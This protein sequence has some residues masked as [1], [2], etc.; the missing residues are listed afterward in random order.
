[1]FRAAAG[2]WIPGP[3]IALAGLLLLTLLV[4]LPG[5]GGGWLFDD[6]PNLTENPTVLAWLA[7]EAG[8]REALG[9][10]EASASG[11]PLAMASLLLPAA[12]HG[13]EPTALKLGNLLLH[14]ANGLL[15]G[16]LLA[17]LAA[18]SA[19]APGAP[20]GWLPLLVAGLWLLAPLQVSTVL[21]VIQRMEI[22]AATAV[23]LGLLAYDAARS[24]MLAAQPGVRLRLWVLFPAALACG[25]LAKESAVAL[26]LLAL[27][28]E[29]LVYRWAGDQA[30]RRELLV[31]FG[32]FLLLPALAGAWL[33]FGYLNPEAYTHRDFGWSERL[34]TQ[35]PVLVDYLRWILLPLPESGF[36]HDHYPVS[37]SLFEPRT[38]SAWALLLGLLVL[39]WSARRAAA[40]FS[41]GI[42]WFLAC[43]LLTALPFPLELVFE[44]R[45]YLALA[46]VWIAVA[47]GLAWL[48]QRLSR[49]SWP[50]LGLAGLLLASTL[51]TAVRAHGWGDPVRLA[52]RLAEHQPQSARAQH[53]LGVLLMQAGLGSANPELLEASFAAFERSARL[54]PSPLG[55]GALLILHGRS[56]RP[57]PDAL[58]DDYMTRVSQPP[59]RPEH[60][61]TLRAI[62]N[63]IADP[64]CKLDDARYTQ[65]LRAALAAR[66]GQRDLRWMLALQL[67]SREGDLAGARAL[68][69]GLV[70]EGDRSPLLY[71]LL[72]YT[73]GK[74]GD[75]EAM[76]G[77]LARH[78]ASAAAQDDL[79]RAAQC[80]P[81]AP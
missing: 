37:R 8:W 10:S 67:L 71:S 38:A 35:G 74:L 18:R 63:C 5:L 23:L 53:A 41:L 52:F 30:Q 43:H 40:W 12:L 73:S 56:G 25:L 39:A 49:P 48:G 65:A 66:P 61:S 32:V 46:G 45:N 79:L 44:H 69:E 29:P 62:A 59:W 3:A 31:F 47:G 60:L 33:L 4:Y 80:E 13:L 34:L 17:R 28:L 57:V 76:A 68:A 15:L 78:R 72:A 54:S 26:P 50:L 22:L 20:S 58:W 24:R 6:G 81:A 19:L 14:L 55:P 64:R 77:W 21:Y 75:C 16:W 36:Y 51:V 2:P 1:M 27:L 42:G 9:A 70:D 7:G 11:R